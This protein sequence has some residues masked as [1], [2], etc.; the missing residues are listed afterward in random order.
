MAFKLQKG[1]RSPSLSLTVR[2]DGD[3]F[4]FTGCTAKLRMRGELVTTPLKV[5]AA[6]QIIAASTTL[7]G[8][9]TLPEATLTVGSTTGFLEEGALSLGGQIVEYEG[10]SAT[11]F[12]GCTGGRGTIANGATVAQIGGVRYDWAAGDVDTA[13]DFRAWVHVILPGGNTQ[14]SPEFPIEI[15][16]HAPVIRP[17]CA[18]ADIFRYVPGYR[19][20]AS[21][22]ETL[23]RLI[24]AESRTL[25]QHHHREF[26]SIVGQPTRL[27]DIRPREVRTRRIR[28][29]DCTTVSTVRILEE[30]AATLVST[31]A[32]SARESLPRT[33]EEW[34]PI[35]QIRLF[36]ETFGG[37]TIVYGQLLEVNGIWGFPQ[38]PENVR[39]AC[40]KLVIVRYLSDV[41]LQGTA[42][43]EAVR[44]AEI[45]V[46]GLLRS[47]SEAMIDYGDP[48][49]A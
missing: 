42:F 11:T 48:P 13:G 8:S 38:I 43:A 15:E 49:F 7:T 2:I 23:E 33:R 26:V 10:K 3:P 20:D 4:D 22:D 24:S 5:D 21:T 46:G 47:A 32:S 40:A 28:I 39:Q 6:A 18:L 44:D 34:E 1:N 27:F 12:L 37:P 31:V 14:D 45:S 35:R 29:G 17:L 9:H 25:H 16:E 36:S 30:D 41:A 19:S